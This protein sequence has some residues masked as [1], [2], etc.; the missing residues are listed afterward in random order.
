MQ[1]A[2]KG[3]AGETV[4]LGARVSP[5]L[6]ERLRRAA[7]TEDRSMSAVVRRAVANYLAQCETAAEAGRDDHV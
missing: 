5:V 6:V 2:T 7:L 1:T 3:T 4:L